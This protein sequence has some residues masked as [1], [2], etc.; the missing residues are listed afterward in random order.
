MKH[1]ISKNRHRSK[2]MRRQDV[3]KPHH[4]GS[5]T[6][7]D[8]KKTNRAWFSALQVTDKWRKI[9]VIIQVLDFSIDKLPRV[10]NWLMNLGMG[11]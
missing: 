1:G 8:C 7:Q 11:L 5:G 6:N 9:E 2:S 10:I 3:Q 4:K